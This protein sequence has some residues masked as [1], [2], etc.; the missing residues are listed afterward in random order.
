MK[1]DRRFLLFCLLFF[2]LTVSFGWR[3]FGCF[4]SFYFSIDTTHV[5]HSR[6]ASS[7][8]YFTIP[9]SPPP[10][11]ATK[12]RNVRVK[13]RRD[14]MCN[15]VGMFDKTIRCHLRIDS[16]SV[17]EGSTSAEV[18]FIRSKKKE[19][20]VDRLTLMTHPQSKSRGRQA[21]TLLIEPT[22]RVM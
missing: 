13:Y 4:R 20:V 1:K 12:K 15:D 17:N 21:I 5:F 9:P 8:S 11:L 2:L 6:T 22:E 7:F 10:S 18:S 19:I 3:W 14:N 16:L